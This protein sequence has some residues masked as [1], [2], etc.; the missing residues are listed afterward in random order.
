MIQLIGHFNTVTVAFLLT[1]IL[2]WGCTVRTEQGPGGL[3]PTPT[4][5]PTRCPG[6]AGLA[7]GSY[8]SAILLG[9]ITKEEVVTYDPT[10][11]PL[12]EYAMWTVDV[13][14]H[15][16]SHP[17]ADQT[18]TVR[19]LLR[20]LQPETT[21][22]NTQVIGPALK[23]GERGILFLLPAEGPGG[24]RIFA[25][26]P[27]LVGMPF[28]RAHGVRYDGYVP[29]K[30]GMALVEYDGDTKEEPLEQFIARVQSGD[31][32][33]FPPLGTT[34]E[35]SSLSPSGPLVFMGQ[36]EGAFQKR[37]LLKNSGLA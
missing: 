2:F 31:C 4:L 16:V 19:G 15:I 9:S 27:E 11:G 3:T 24:S 34:R 6:E 26:S 28:F 25:L 37:P 23:V 20:V 1:G 18:V 30:N 35:N 21:P 29:V 32:Q 33:R 14:Q 22:S 17:L 5:D 10:D 7:Y 12:G 36:K 8:S 13:E